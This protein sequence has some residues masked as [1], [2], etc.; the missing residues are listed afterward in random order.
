MG[1]M[2]WAA[3][4]GPDRLPD[5]IPTHFDMAGRANGWGSPSLMLL[6]PAIAVG[7]YLLLTVVSRFPSAF[8]HPIASTPELLPRLRSVTQTMLI[9]LKA[10]L[11]S[12]FAALQ[13]IFIHSARTGEGH[14][15]AQILPVVILVVLGTLT[16]YL[17]A[18]V[19]CAGDPAS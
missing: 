14:L 17:I 5:R 4:H 2:T 3:L 11:T 19:R 7:T 6:M 1:I 9:L 18:M 16:W 12:L 8:N 15:F 10:E 13:W